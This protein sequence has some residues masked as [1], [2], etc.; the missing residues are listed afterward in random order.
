MKTL[1]I[2][3]FILALTYALTGCQTLQSIPKNCTATNVTF[4]PLKGNY[5]IC[6]TCDSLYNLKLVKTLPE[7]AVKQGVMKKAFKK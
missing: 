4:D 3:A 6:L 5:G 1:L 2:I 7:S